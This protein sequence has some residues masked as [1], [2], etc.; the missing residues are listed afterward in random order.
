MA[1][2]VRRITTPANAD[3]ERGQGPGGEREAGQREDI[4]RHQAAVLGE[5]RLVPP[6]EHQAEQRRA[7]SQAHREQHQLG[8]DPAQPAS[9]LGPGEPERAGLKLA[10]QQR[11]AGEDPDQYRDDEEDGREPA[12]PDVVLLVE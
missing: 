6:G 12:D 11:A 3:G 8:G 9:S 5:E 1:G 4:L 2:T 10:G 7:D